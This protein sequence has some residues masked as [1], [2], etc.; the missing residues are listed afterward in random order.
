MLKRTGIA[1]VLVLAACTT[2]HPW[3][4]AEKFKR[5][6]RCGMTTDQI[7]AIANKYKARQHGGPSIATADPLSP[8][9]FVLD[10]STYFSLRYEHGRLSTVGEGHV[11]EGNDGEE[12]VVDRVI[13]LCGNRNVVEPLLKRNARSSSP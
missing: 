4:N 11:E 2:E 1:S 10:G 7:A 13:Y 8:D 9:Y 6:L 3:R 12:T 5:D